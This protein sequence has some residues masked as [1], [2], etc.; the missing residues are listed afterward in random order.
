MHHHIE[1]VHQYPL[2]I[3]VAFYLV[4]SHTHNFLDRLVDGIAQG[5]DVRRHVARGY[6]EILR[7]SAVHLPQVEHAHILGFLLIHYLGRQLGKHQ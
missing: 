7:R 2:G 4:R 3:V 6:H 1:I 5:T